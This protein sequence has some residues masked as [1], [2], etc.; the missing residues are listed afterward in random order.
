MSLLAPF[1]G[2]EQADTAS[3]TSDGV[4][5]RCYVWRSTVSNR[6]EAQIFVEQEHGQDVALRVGIVRVPDSPEIVD[7]PRVLASG[8][9]FVVHWVESNGTFGEVRLWEL[10]RATLD[11]STTNPTTWTCRGAA[12]LDTTALYDACPV[13]GHADEYVVARRTDADE[14]AVVRY[15]G[16]DWVDTVWFSNVTVETAPRVL[17]VYCHDADNDCVVSYQ[18]ID[19]NAYQLWSGHLDAD[20]GGSFVQA[21]TFTEIFDCE[22]VQV[23]HCRVGSRQVAVVV[24]YQEVTGTDPV[25]PSENYIHG[26]AFRRIASS[27]CATQSNEHWAW[28]L[29]LCSRP[30]T[31]PS[32]RSSSGGSPDVY[33]LVSFKGLNDPFQWSQGSYFVVNLDYAHWGA[34]ADGPTLRPRP[35][36]NLNS[37]G[38]ADSRPS[39]A[40]SASGATLLP[41]P[42]KRMNHVSSV[43]GAPTF[44]SSPD[45]KS[46]TV[47]AIVF[48]RLSVRRNDVDPGVFNAESFADLEPAN[49]GVVGYKCLA[50]DP[51]TLRRDGSSEP[52]E[53]FRGAYPWSQHQHVESGRGLVVAGGTPHVFDGQALV[54]LGFA[55]VPELLPYLVATGS[56]EPRIFTWVAV[57]T[58]RDSAG[59]IHRSG[60]SAPLRLSITTEEPDVSFAV[61]P[62]TLTLK[63]NDFHYPS[64]G[65]INL[66]LFRTEANDTTL[67][68]VYGQGLGTYVPANTPVN[69]PT[70]KYFLVADDVAD[71]ALVFGGEFNLQMSGAIGWTTLVPVQP[72]ASSVIAVWNNRVWLA[73][74]QD[75]TSIW[76]SS[77]VLPRYGDIFY[78]APEFS[79]VCTFRIDGIG[80]VTAM[81]PM[82]NA[83]VIFTRDA[84][85]SL[86]GN[87]AD[88]T[89]A[90]ANL[91][92]ETLH[93]G[94]GCIEPRSIVLAPNGIYF[95]SFKGIYLLDRGRSLDFISAGASVE[96]EILSSGNVRSATLLEDR[97]QIRFCIDGAPTITQTSV[98]DLAGLDP[99]GTWSILFVEAGVTVTVEQS[100]GETTADVADELEAAIEAL[101]ASTLLG[102]VAS[103]SALGS[104]LTVVFADGVHDQ[105]FVLG[106]PSGA[107]LSVES[108]EDVET[109][110]RVLLYDYYHRL[111][112][113]LD[114]V[115]TSTNTHLS[116]IAS[117][118]AWRGLDGRVAHVVL[119]QGALLVERASNDALAYTDQTSTGNVG[120]PIDVQTSWIHVAGIAGLQRVRSMG[121]QLAKPNDSSIH[122]DLDFDIDGDFDEFNGL[123]ETFD[124]ASP[125]PAYLRVRPSIQKFTST[126]VRVYEDVGA[127]NLENVSITSITFEIGSK[128]GLRRV[129]DTQIGT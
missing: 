118:C 28:Q 18:R 74:G 84:I 1:V 14:L 64:C 63:D 43:S 69:D 122:V 68:R 50:E 70:V 128:R 39:G 126:R 25:F 105:T 102:V 3:L 16:P 44:T 94:T 83:L 90:N 121:V 57:F 55:W 79:D 114:L 4:F 112:S 42:A 124:W 15:D 41:G 99:I 49:A 103:A 17:G 96:D 29:H 113:R 54:E 48:A 52:E 117:G 31:H 81:Q 77:E 123:S 11:M 34:A 110:P 85:Y 116:K 92:V 100:S 5:Y 125:A 21:Q 95:Q 106:D 45:L 107:T 62:I 23:G 19:A 22:F 51:W 73:T 80:E 67:F 33:C 91:S 109:N 98:F 53:N 75:T 13:I 104:T 47:A 7:C 46:V 10:H 86:I 76:Y 20:D 119:Q 115:Q 71:A 89:G 8:T 82:N 88:G 111:W 97:H 78:A 72:P 6:V 56:E 93:E 66:E 37:L 108:T 65:P 40:T 61:R 27:D 58:W 35:V 9:T 129:S 38:I 26:V 12:A 2:H 36:A 60:P 87:G 101:L 59:Q 32:G 120:I 127:P 30:W 24:E